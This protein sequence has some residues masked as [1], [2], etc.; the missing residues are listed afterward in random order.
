MEEFY[1]AWEPWEE[2]WGLY[3]LADIDLDGPITL[4]DSKEELEEFILSGE[5]QGLL[6]RLVAFISE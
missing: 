3:T 5:A 4:S 1:V 2:A 6:N